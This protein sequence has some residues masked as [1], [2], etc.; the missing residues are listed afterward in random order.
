MGCLS[1][2]AVI[3]ALAGLVSG[4][5]GAEPADPAIPAPSVRT[6]ARR[7]D[8]VT[9]EY[10]LSMRKQ[11]EEGWVI[12]SFVVN[13]DGTVGNALVEDSSGQADFE[14]AALKAIAQQRFNP[15]TVDGKPVEQCVTRVMYMFAIDGNLG[16]RKKFRDQ[17]RVVRDALAGPDQDAALK[18]LT[19]MRK[20]DGWNN[21][22]RSRLELLRYEFCEKQGNTTCVLDSLLRA[23]TND[24]AFLEKNLYR[25]VLEATAAA[26]IKLELFKDAISTIEK[27]SKRNP[28]LPADHPLTKAASQVRD[29]A[30]S[31]DLLSFA[32]ELQVRS[33][34]HSDTPYWRHQLLR[35]EFAV[36]PVEGNLDRLEIRCDWRRATDKVSAERTWKIPE[37]WG[38]CVVYVFGNEGAKVKLI[39]YPL[40][41]K[42]A[43]NESLPAAVASE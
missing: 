24:G 27:R 4:V 31:Q 38:D 8:T 11:G 33:A 3:G 17:F 19:E 28:P 39:E 34:Q 12:T 32:G 26:Q 15:A 43:G 10:P 29:L 42:T 2:M 9:P 23:A 36:D 1:R 40:E 21:Y 25:Q 41:K 13:T 37:S 16:A 18:A 7:V 5:V 6:D 30:A 14:R 20:A 22:E 35:R